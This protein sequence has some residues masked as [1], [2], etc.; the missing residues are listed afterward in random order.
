MNFT[1]AVMPLGD[2]VVA[3]VIGQVP[4]LVVPSVRYVTKV[5]LPFVRCF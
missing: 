5:Q 4:L 1:P 2:S 3:Q